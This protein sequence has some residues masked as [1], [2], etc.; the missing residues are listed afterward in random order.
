MDEI[1]G[2]DNAE[3]ETNFHKSDQS[4]RNVIYDDIEKSGEETSYPED[5]E[6]SR[7]DD[8]NEPVGVFENELLSN[9]DCNL[10]MLPAIVN[11]R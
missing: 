5:E 3:N 7:N 2:S 1:P 10:E 8:F 4:G 11:G 6:D 9:L